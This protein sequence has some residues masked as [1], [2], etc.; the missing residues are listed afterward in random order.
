MYR[1]TGYIRALRVLL[2][3]L[4]QHWGL[5]PS[6]SPE[7]RR[8]QITVPPL[9]E[10]LHYMSPSDCKRAPVRPSLAAH[11]PTDGWPLSSALGSHTQG[12]STYRNTLKNSH[13]LSFSILLKRGP[14][15]LHFILSSD[16]QA[17][18]AH[19]SFI[20]CTQ[21]AGRLC[22]QTGRGKKVRDIGRLCD[23]GRRW[24]W[25]K[26]HKAG[27]PAGLHFQA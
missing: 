7:S 17:A 23:L 4:R 2:D 15:S 27:G 8:L 10:P 18:R 26:R 22:E 20:N 21:P 12:C 11:V 5:L 3:N 16:G 6:S 13:L 1:D 25:N 19:I 14:S 9:L 24:P